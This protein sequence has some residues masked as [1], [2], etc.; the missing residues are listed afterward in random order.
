MKPHLQTVLLLV[1]VIAG[2][3]V[4]ALTG[5]LW[6]TLLADCVAGFACGRIV[7]IVAR[8]ST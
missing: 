1:V 7:R 8:G 3:T 6:L 5:R 4:G 2:T